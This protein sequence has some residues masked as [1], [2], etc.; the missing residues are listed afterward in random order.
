MNINFTDKF[1]FILFKL[2]NLILIE[3]F[4]NIINIYK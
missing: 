4:F 3:F 2:L 1:F